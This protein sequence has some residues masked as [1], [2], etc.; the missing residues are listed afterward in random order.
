MIKKFKDTAGGPRKIL[1][2]RERE[3]ERERNIELRRLLGELF[4]LKDHTAQSGRKLQNL[5]A[6]V[7]SRNHFSNFFI[8]KI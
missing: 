2:E 8:Q 4:Y 5:L 7:E 3:R 1:R 6:T